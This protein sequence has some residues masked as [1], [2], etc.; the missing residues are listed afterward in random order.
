MQ[1]NIDA[2]GRTRP[3]ASVGIQGSPTGSRMKNE[4][5]IVKEETTSQLNGLRL[6]RSKVPDKEVIGEEWPSIFDQGTCCGSENF[7]GKGN[8][9]GE[10]TDCA[11]RGRGKEKSRPNPGDGSAK[12]PSNCTGPLRTK[13]RTLIQ[14]LLGIEKGGRTPGIRESTGKM[15]KGQGI[16]HSPRN[17][18]NNKNQKN[19]NRGIGS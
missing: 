5:D 9:D 2:L 6:R 8:E 3:A 16:V 18:M 17:P 19:F 7:K 10:R 1:V 11:R 4:A 12:R 13:N 14:S 15:Q